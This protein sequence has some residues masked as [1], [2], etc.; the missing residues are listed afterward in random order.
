MGVETI[1]VYY[2][3]RICHF[4]NK[5]KLLLM[6]PLSGIANH[7]EILLLFS[8]GGGG[9]VTVRTLRR[10]RSFVISLILANEVKQNSSINM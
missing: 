6:S 4:L 2:T 1:E 9:I 7:R 10:V 8:G 3:N 5:G